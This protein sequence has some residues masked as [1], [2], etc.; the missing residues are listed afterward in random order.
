MP[1]RH[2]WN[3]WDNYLRVH[4]S[5]LNSRGHF[6]ERND[7]DY[8]FSEYVVLWK[9]VL[10]CRDTIEIHVTKSQSVRF[11]SGRPEVRTDSYS[12]HAQKR[13]DD[14]VIKLMR[15]DN[16]HIHPGHPTIH[17]R[18]RYDDEGNEIFPVECIGEDWPTLG[19]F[20]DE[21]IGIWESG[22]ST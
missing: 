2:D 19:D 6:I 13:T 14:G 12:Y 20:I 22:T 3:S 8:I 11:R 18:H 4:E 17:H 9:G 16:A 5:F 15:Y 10:Y 21:I 1:D 7:L